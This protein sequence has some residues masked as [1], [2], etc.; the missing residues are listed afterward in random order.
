MKTPVFV[1][2]LLVVIFFIILLSVLVIRQILKKSYEKAVINYQNKLLSQEMEEVQH[3]YLTMRGWRHDYHNHMQSIK[4]YLAK[5]NIEEARAYPDKL[6][7][8]L[9]DIRLLF[10]TGNLN[11]DAILNAKISLALENGIP[12]D[13]K[14]VIP[15]ELPVSDLDLCV[16]IGNLI[17]NAVE[18]CRNVPKE[19]QF[20]RLYIG[21]LKKQLYISVS[22]ATNEVVRKIDSEYISEKRG[23]HGH[24]LQRINDAVEKNAGFINRKNEP[25]VFV[26]EIMLPLAGTAVK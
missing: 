22:N 6:E 9:D 26:T 25:G 11:V 21:P 7:T 18:S 20:L 8:D 3:I 24:G 12:C 10:D 5:D 17:D 15:K 13:Y 4:A 2:L 1:C 19:K 14:A 23:D 16:I